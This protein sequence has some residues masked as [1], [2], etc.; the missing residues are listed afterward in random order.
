MKE[1]QVGKQTLPVVEHNDFK[2]PFC[3]SENTSKIN[4]KDKAMQTYM[5][6]NSPL[7][8]IGSIAILNQKKFLDKNSVDVVQCNR[9]AESYFMERKE[10]QKEKPK[11]VKESKVA[12]FIQKAFLTYCGIMCIFAIFNLLFR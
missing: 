4:S 5:V 1:L 6:L 12:K 11:P 8:T 2:C 3:G 7:A 9:C 10:I